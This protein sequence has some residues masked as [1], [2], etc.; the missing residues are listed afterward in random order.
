MKQQLPLMLLG[1]TFAFAEP[2]YLEQRVEALEKEVSDLKEM[3]KIP[4]PTG[5]TPAV[6]ETVAKA[7]EFLFF[8]G[9]EQGTSLWA[10]KIGVSLAYYN[11][12]ETPQ[13]K[14][15]ITK[16]G[17]VDK[18]SGSPWR[19]TKVVKYQQEEI[20]APEGKRFLTSANVEDGT[21]ILTTPLSKTSG[22]TKEWR[23]AHYLYTKSALDLSSLSLPVMQ[24]SAQ[25]DPPEKLNY[26]D[27]YTGGVIVG[28][29]YEGDTVEKFTPL[30][31]LEKPSKSWEEYEAD[32]SSADKF[33][34]I[35]LVFV[36]T[37]GDSRFSKSSGLHLDNVR[38]FD[39][40]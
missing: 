12:I 26:R 25:V 16:S 19:S 39:D 8:D 34:P 38:I 22:M 36:Y 15:Y 31:R 35:H 27:T 32:L 18:I 33:K 37:C 13:S 3:L 11:A 4:S 30:I 14:D 20:S 10:E 7:S 5:T 2:L 23:G 17:G 1:C 40:H 28:Y 9:F 6:K 21:V 24:F 29:Y